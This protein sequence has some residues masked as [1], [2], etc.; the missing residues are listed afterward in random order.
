M[1]EYLNLAEGPFG[2]LSSGNQRDSLC[3]VVWEKGVTR[4]HQLTV[5]TASQTRMS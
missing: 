2:G 4:H 5:V 3:L 1:Y